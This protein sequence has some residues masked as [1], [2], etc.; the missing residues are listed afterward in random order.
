[1]SYLKLLLTVAM[2]FSLA[3]CTS[4]PEIP[5]PDP[6]EATYGDDASTEGMGGDAYGD[7]ELS[8]IHISEPTRLQ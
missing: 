4:S 8:L 3:A 7:G 5:D 6:T 1:M 2:V